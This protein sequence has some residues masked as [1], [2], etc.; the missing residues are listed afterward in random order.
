MGGSACETLLSSNEATRHTERATGFLSARPA[1]CV[2]HTPTLS[3]SS[4]LRGSGER[5]APVTE[6]S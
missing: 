3:L 1:S 4:P 6:L 5:E 2:T